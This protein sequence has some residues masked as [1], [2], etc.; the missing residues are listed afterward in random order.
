MG[1]VGE[2][3][4]SQE[5]TGGL[6]SMVGSQ[7]GSAG[8]SRLQELGQP[9]LI[10][11]SAVPV[12]V[13]KPRFLRFMFWLSAGLLSLAGLSF[14]AKEYAEVRISV[15]GMEAYSMPVVVL[16]AIVVGVVI[17][18]TIAECTPGYKPKVKASTSRSRGVARI[19]RSTTRGWLVR[20]RYA[21]VRLAPYRHIWWA[22]PLVVGLG[23]SPLLFAQEMLDIERTPLQSLW[24]GCV[25]HVPFWLGAVFVPPP[26]LGYL[27][28][29]RVIARKT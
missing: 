29:T 8:L 14:T 6:Q 5:E 7:R 1:I 9:P 26:A 10:S 19:T 21:L 3:P 15:P 13:H 4:M 12:S 16:V 22:T 2:T 28:Y 17:S 23:L 11:F 20:M 18:Q 27:F 25:H 24:Y